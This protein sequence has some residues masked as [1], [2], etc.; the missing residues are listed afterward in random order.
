M[1]LLLLN[2]GEN[3]LYK[4]YHLLKDS[5]ALPNRYKLALVCMRMQKYEEAEKALKLS[6]ELQVIGGAAGCYLL[7]TIL[8]RQARHKDAVKFYSKAVELDPTMWVAFEKLC[9]L[10][11][12]VNSEGMFREE[13]PVLAGLNAVISAKDY[14]NRTGQPLNGPIQ[15]GL[16][17]NLKFSPSHA[18]REQARS[19][20]RSHW[21]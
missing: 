18:G 2:A 7:G 12:R 5:N 13:H 19:P 11:P 14:F 15:N 9:K 3:K 17:G 8:E 6:E 21:Q 4:A 20:A 16:Q 1:V 10:E